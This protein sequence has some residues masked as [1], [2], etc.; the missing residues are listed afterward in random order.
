[1]TKSCPVCDEPINDGEEIAAVVKSTMKML[2]SKLAYAITTPTECVE[3]MH[4]RCTDYT[5][6][7]PSA[8]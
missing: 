7:N 8:N 5:K 2:P 6:E 3:V 1:M 4:W